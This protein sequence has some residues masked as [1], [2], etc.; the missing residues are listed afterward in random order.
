MEDSIAARDAW[1]EQ[2]SLIRLAGTAIVHTPHR[3]P[4]TF[5]FLWERTPHHRY[6]LILMDPSTSKAMATFITQDAQS[7]ILQPGLDPQ[8]PTT[9]W[10]P[11]VLLLGQ[12]LEPQMAMNWALGLP[13]KPV[14]VEPDMPE[15]LQDAGGRMGELHQQGWVITYQDWAPATATLPALPKRLLLTGSTARIE[16]SLGEIQAYAKPPAD[17]KEFNIQ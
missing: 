7:M 3:P 2:Q 6:A 13:A 15:V 14:S 10:V 8:S 5:S 17:Y 11:A 12:Q 4:Q 1:Q 9:P 16:L